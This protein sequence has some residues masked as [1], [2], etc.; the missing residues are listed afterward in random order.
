MVVYIILEGISQKVK[1][2]A[3]LKFELAYCCDAGKR[4]MRETQKS[5]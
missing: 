2:I 4:K 5:R 1:V 3:R